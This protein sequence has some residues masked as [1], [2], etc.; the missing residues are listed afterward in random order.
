MPLMTSSKSP[1]LQ[2]GSIA[3]VSFP[4]TDLPILKKR[5]ALIIKRHQF[6]ALGVMYWAAMITSQIETL[7]EASDVD[8][9]D[10]N[11]AGLLTPS[12]I[13]LGIIAT[14]KSEL[15]QKQLGVLSKTDFTSV[16]L[17]WSDLTKDWLSS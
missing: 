1:E 14:I 3:L 12:R 17:T 13:R 16:R 2:P 10:W 15:V 11:S 9:T 6:H 7:A 4:F 5:P 8:V